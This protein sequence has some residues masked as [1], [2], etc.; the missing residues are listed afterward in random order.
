M[1]Q[2]ALNVATPLK[3][4]GVSNRFPRAHTEVD[5]LEM[6]YNADD[7]TFQ[8]PS[9]VRGHHVYKSVKTP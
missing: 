3:W 1:H 9:V 2:S 8:L 7:F 5:S 4:R 6:A